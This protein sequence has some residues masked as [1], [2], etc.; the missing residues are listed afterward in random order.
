MGIVY[1]T[2]LQFIWLILPVNGFEHHVNSILHYALIVKVLGMPIDIERFILCLVFTFWK[3]LVLLF[4]KYENQFVFS[5]IF[6]II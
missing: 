2:D 3:K 6:C 4:G 5:V 1:L